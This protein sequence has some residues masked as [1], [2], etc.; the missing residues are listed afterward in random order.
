MGSGCSVAEALGFSRSGR[1]RF[2]FPC[3]HLEPEARVGDRVRRGVRAVW[4][5]CRRCNVIALAMSEDPGSSTAHGTI[6]R[7]SRT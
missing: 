7:G 2:Q 6:G 3:G 5:G 1:R 4:V